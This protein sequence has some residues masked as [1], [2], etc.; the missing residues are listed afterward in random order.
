MTTN[1]YKPTSL[2][3]CAR[4]AWDLRVGCRACSRL[5]TWT[6]QN[7]ARRF[8]RS[9]GAT[10]QDLANKVRCDGCG[11]RC[12]FQIVQGV[13]D[14]LGQGGMAGHDVTERREAAFVA[15]LVEID[16]ATP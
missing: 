16:R 8:R 13:T 11:G 3:D 9:L 1:V 5:E 2:A 14:W 12:H 7:I 6:H 10:T 4:Y 15:L